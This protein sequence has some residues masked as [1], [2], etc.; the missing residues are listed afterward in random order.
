[1]SE[2]LAKHANRCGWGEKTERWPL[3]EIDA[4]GNLF[5]THDGKPVTYSRQILAEEFYWMEVEWGGPGLIHDEEAEEFRT[6]SGELALSRERVS[7][8]HLMGPRR[9]ED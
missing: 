4:D 8:T 7:F 5:C 9:M 6:P 1:M 2:N 3:F